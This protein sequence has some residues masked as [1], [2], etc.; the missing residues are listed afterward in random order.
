MTAP[1][2]AN[3]YTQGTAV[4]IATATPFTA[5]DGVTIVDPDVVLFGFQVDGISSQTYNFIYTHPTGDPTGTIVRT[6]IGTYQATIDTSLY[7]SGVWVYMFGC[8]PSA[9]VLFDTTKTK[10]R[11]LGELIVEPAP[12]SMG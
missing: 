6:A 10:V 2:S 7:P 12:F 9:D 3:T 8:E 11:Q 1:V 4:T 5:N